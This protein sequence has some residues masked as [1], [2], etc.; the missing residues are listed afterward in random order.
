[1]LQY[2][3]ASWLLALPLA[4]A[5]LADDMPVYDA[6]EIL[7][8]ASGV[9]QA[10]GVAPVSETV[11][12]AQDIANSSARTVPEVLATAA[13]VHLI[14]SGGTNPTIDLR[15]F[16]MTGSS[17]TLILV[18]GIKQNTADGS[19]PDLSYIPL[20]SIERI[21]IVRGS[22]AVQYGG[23]AT[24]GVINIITKDRLPDGQH[25][26]LGQTLG[27]FN[28]RQSDLN[29]QLTSDRVRLTGYA[30][31][32][33]T[34]HFR[35][36]N[37]EAKDSGGGK[38]AWLLDEGKLTVYARSS[39]DSQGLPGGRTVN[40]ATGENQF[41][42]DPSGSAMLA[43]SGTRLIDEGGL[44]VN[45]RLGKGWL[46]LDIASRHKAT[47]TNY[48]SSAWFDRRQSQED[49]GS[50]RYALPFSRD[51]QWVLGLDW[52]NGSGTDNN[53]NYSPVSSA[54]TT[55]V[56]QATQR[57][58]GLFSELQIA[59]RDG[60]RVTAGGRVQ[61]MNDQVDCSSTGCTSSRDKR[62]LHAWQL[63]I[64]QALGASWS[65][66]AKQ[67]QSF[68]LPSTDELTGTSQ[69]LQPQTS[70]DQEVGLEWQREQDQM[71]IA[72]FRS[73][74]ENEIQYIPYAPNGMFNG[75]NI[76]LSP[77]RHEGIELEGSMQSSGVLR[78]YGNLTW[79]RA[80][81]RR[82]TYGGV[83]L[84][85]NTIPQI[86][87]WL[88]NMGISWQLQERSRFNLEGSFTGCTRL[89]NDQNNQ[90]PVQVGAY[91]LLNAKLAHQFSKQLSGS[92]TINN[93]LNRQYASYGSLATS[94]AYYN[95]YPGDPRNY[96]ATISWSF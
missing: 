95:L 54:I 15:G 80:R 86:P 93:L 82:G 61:Q 24:G 26:A 79:Q 30:Q 18:D 39:R 43:N 66:Y 65:V 55:P 85:G 9:P 60:L 41:V 29:F 16:G 36:N 72:L 46:Y 52:R 76:N 56:A 84:T 20:S 31:S 96:Q 89:D 69:P 1:M 73:D 62:T 47:I 53:N 42:Y 51:N 21:E 7:V 90:Y 57:H 88:V 94:G 33:R 12:T 74:L 50:L 63:G 23:G 27:S 28:L 17:N 37:A 14:S 10:R 91:F 92:L 25:L 32:M 78:V 71:R 81:Y 83:D 38:L 11:I 44:Q 49:S 34:D 59:V 77:T 4:G 48:V 13:G 40:P 64:R 87:S 75:T 22:G 5:V 8:T 68:R 2:K 3:Y 45:H 67:G 58:Q 6:G 19:A 35:Q 70:R